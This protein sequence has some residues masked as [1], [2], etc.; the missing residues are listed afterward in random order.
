MSILIV[1][2]CDEF[3]T[4]VVIINNTKQE[5]TFEHELVTDMIELVTVFSA[6]LY[7]SCSRQNQKL[8]EK[9]SQNCTKRFE[10]IE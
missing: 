2:I 3:Q 6:R 4:Q 8:V 5:K 7:G 10:K 1:M 9:C